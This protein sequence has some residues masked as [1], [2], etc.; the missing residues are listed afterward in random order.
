MKNT[1]IEERK[2]KKNT[3]R[4][5]IDALFW[6]KER[7]ESNEKRQFTKTTRETPFLLKEPIKTRKK[8]YR[9]P[10]SK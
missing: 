3:K 1:E 7:N 4:N 9:N 6:N 10:P 8:L 2:R 5:K